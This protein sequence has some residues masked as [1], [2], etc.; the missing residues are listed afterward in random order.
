MK[1]CF[2]IPDGVGI[3]NY[4]FSSLIGNLIDSDIAI[5]IWHRLDKAVIANIEELHSKEFENIPLTYESEPLAG[6]I[7]K[8]AAV[9]AR[10]K[11]NVRLDS[12]PTTFL[13]W[14][15]KDKPFKKRLLLQLSESIGKLLK[16]YQSILIA[17]KFYYQKI[18]ETKDFQTAIQ[19]LK[20]SKPDLLFCTHQ[21]SP[22]AAMAIEAAKYLNI[23][24]VSVIYSWDNLPKG[25]LVVKSDQYIVWSDYMKAEL[26][27]YYPEI[28]EDQIFVLGTPQFDFH[29][30][31]SKIEEREKF[32][33]VHNLDP[34]KNWI[35]F[36]GDD[37]M[38]SPYDPLFLRDLAE[39][40]KGMNNVELIFRPVPVSGHSRYL[41]VL[42]KSPHIKVIS[43]R[44]NR[45]ESW[46]YSYPLYEDVSMLSTLAA[47]CELVLNVGSTMALDFACFNKPSIYLNYLPEGGDEKFWKPS[48][49]YDRQHFRTMND[50]DAVCWGNSKEEL[51]L[52]I[53]KI[54]QDPQD[55]AKGRLDWLNLVRKDNGS[56]GASKQIAT[57]ILNTV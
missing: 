51:G 3:R 29:T 2:V 47:H 31:V 33:S 57:F 48:M 6:R 54:I 4:L 10:L 13:D 53:K 27:K 36:S 21:R 37:E 14:N 44:W 41:E 17:E 5:S 19:V 55:V 24:T 32:A 22:E 42:S 30:D 28:I 40:T 8:E 34:G 18:K 23:P 39:V 20:K 9:Y 12:N 16:N 25:R 1:V 11:N 35:C 56:E 50:K 46:S 43:P 15:I 49:I 45:S 26:I 7:F 52:L 38:T